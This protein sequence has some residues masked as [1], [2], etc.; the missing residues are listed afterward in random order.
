M[1]IKT[2]GIIS[3]II[4]REMSI[5]FPISVDEFKNNLEKEFPKLL[6]INYFMAINEVI[7]H[8]STQMI[9]ENDVIAV[10]PPFS[11]G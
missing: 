6:E 4:H 7:I 2:F 3:S 8:D 11:G 5:H 1:N 9:Q 10:L